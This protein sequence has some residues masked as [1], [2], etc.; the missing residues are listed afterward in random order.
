MRR[1][2]A[3]LAIATLAACGG[4]KDGTTDTGGTTGDDDDDACANSVIEAFPADGATDVYYRSTVR[5]TLAAEDTAASVMVMDSA[6]GMVNGTTMVEGNI[7]R[8]EGD[9]LAPNST[10]DVTLSYEC[11]DATVSWT[12]SDVGGTTSVDLTGKVY[13]LDLTSGEWEQP[14][15]VGDLLA[16]QLGDVEVLISPLTVGATDIQMIGGLG[17]GSG[18]QDLCTETIPFPPANWTDPY[19]EV[20]APSLALTVSGFTVNIDDLELSGA[21]APDGSRIQGAVL[22]GAINTIPLVELI[23]PGGADDAVCQLVGTF[24]VSCESCS[25]G[26]GDYCL[27]VWVQNIEALEVPGGTLVERLAADIA[28][29]PAC[30]ATTP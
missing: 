21:F 8:W 9:P 28:A 26:S 6:G 10:Y 2:L 16:T 17:D 23:A 13:G 22:K 4:D 12:T 7:V 3:I 30:G 24:G 11:G 5:F 20:T 19:F 18:G 25:D 27:S 15:G 29:D 1:Y 14:A